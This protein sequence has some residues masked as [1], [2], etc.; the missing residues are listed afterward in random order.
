MIIF[1][2]MWEFSTQKPGLETGL[3]RGRSFGIYYPCSIKGG[4]NYVFANKEIK[5]S[6]HM[7]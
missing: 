6:T 3:T 7:Q 4:M 5:V 1:M 2:G